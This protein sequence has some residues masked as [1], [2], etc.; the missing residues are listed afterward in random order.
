MVVF[1]LAASLG[2]IFGAYLTNFVK[3]KQLEK[4]FG[5]FVIAVAIFILIKR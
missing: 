3:P 4:G 2:T 5:Y 1:T